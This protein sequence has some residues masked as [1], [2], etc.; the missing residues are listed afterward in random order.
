MKGKVGFVFGGLAAIA[1]V[2]AW[3]CVPELKSRTTSE[4]DAMFTRGVPARKMGKYELN[5][6]V[7]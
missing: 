3:L 7:G 1:T 2:G 6:V 4:I 5:E